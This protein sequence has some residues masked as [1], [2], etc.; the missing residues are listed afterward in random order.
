M[1]PDLHVWII[2]LDAHLLLSIQIINSASAHLE[3]FNIG[4]DGVGLFYL[5]LYFPKLSS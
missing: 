1:I 5:R 4:I 3:N 2:V